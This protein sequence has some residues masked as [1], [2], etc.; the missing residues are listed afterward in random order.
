[1]K[2]TYELINDMEKFYVY[3]PTKNT[4]TYFACAH[5][6]VN[7]KFMHA[8]KKKESGIYVSG[9]PAPCGARYDRTVQMF[10]LSRMMS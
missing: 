9:L 5:I 10:C 6:G 1:M 3:P 2:Q 4:D 8:Q 7:T